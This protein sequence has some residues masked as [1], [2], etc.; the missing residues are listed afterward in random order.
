MILLINIIIQFI[1]LM[2]PIEIT[3]DFYVESHEDF[4]K[5]KS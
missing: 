1:E 5:K 3:D 2:K 4:N